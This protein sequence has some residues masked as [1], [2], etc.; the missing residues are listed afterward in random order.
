MTTHT[1][2]GNRL[3]L[4]SWWLKKLGKGYRGKE[5]FIINFI[6]GSFCCLLQCQF[7]D[8]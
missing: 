1:D 5:I 4:V 2:E 3:E 6:M 8:N 7:F